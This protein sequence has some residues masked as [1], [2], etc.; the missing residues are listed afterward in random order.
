LWSGSSAV[1]THTKKGKIIIITPV[2]K[3]CVRHEAIEEA[4]DIAPPV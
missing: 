4:E 2:V 1:N 3:L